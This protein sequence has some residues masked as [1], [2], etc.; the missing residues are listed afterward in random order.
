MGKQIIWPI[1][2]LLSTSSLHAQSL[3]AS[4]RKCKGAY[5]HKDYPEALRFAEKALEKDSLV[6]DALFIGGES[7]R[8][9]RKFELAVKYF[10][11]L[12]GPAKKGVYADAD[13][14]LGL[15]QKS[16]GKYGEAMQSFRNCLAQRE[17]ENDLVALRIAD[18]METCMWAI[19][20]LEKT[21]KGVTSVSE[22]YCDQ[23]AT[24]SQF[25]PLRY[26]DKIYFSAA[27]PAGKDE[28]PV[29][30]IFTR[31]QDFPARYFEGN[32]KRP[33]ISASNVALMP[34]ASRIYYTI[35]HDEEYFQ[36]KRCEIWSRDRNYEGDWAAPKRL[37]FPVNMR[38]FTSTQPSIGWERS[39]KKYVLFFSSDRPG[40]KGKM[41]IW[42]VPIDRHGNLGE[43]TCLEANTAEDEVTPFFHQASQTLFFS[44]DGRPG[45]G[46][47]DIFQMKKMEDGTWTAPENMDAPLNTSHDD[48][49]Y[50]WN[51]G[52]Q[53]AYFSSNRDNR[54][55]PDAPKGDFCTDIF[56]AEIFATLAVQA[57]DGFNDMPIEN[58]TVHIASERDELPPLVFENN[59]AARPKIILA[60]G[61]KYEVTVM[62]PGY[63]P[64]QFLLNMAYLT[65]SELLDKEVVLR[66]VKVVKP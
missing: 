58:F 62:A 41:D 12:P 51:M 42:Q 57:V 11:R 63:F 46:G 2:I 31:T 21:Q 15:C 52:A 60:I 55:C 3:R 24:S 40:G 18:E 39:I 4:L 54:E 27:H 64:Q 33:D 5:Y 45:L 25:A 59:A 32:P 7:A 49:Y 53:K 26:A 28:P 43:A 6:A 61:R 48:L 65:K 22:M 30:R 16:L 50:T 14:Q 66:R 1:I 34:D 17:G 10:S 37:G 20:S 8:Q 36:Q 56:E 23:S 35:C 38:G 47:F 9:L 29:S 44:S 19:H 13:F